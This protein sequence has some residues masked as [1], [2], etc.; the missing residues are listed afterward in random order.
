MTGSLNPANKQR[1]ECLGYCNGGISLLIENRANITKMRA[2]VRWLMLYGDMK[3]LKNDPNITYT[4][5]EGRDPF[6]D[7]Y[8]KRYSH[9]KRER[10][11]IRKSPE[12]GYLHFAQCSPDVPSPSCTAYMNLPSYRD[13]SVQYSFSMDHFKDWTAVQDAV[14]RTVDSFV[15]GFVAPKR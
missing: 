4:K 11:Y 2:Y 6:E 14:A 9:G 13:V 5:F 3:R 1:K 12:G 7:V 15:V 10:Y 8:E